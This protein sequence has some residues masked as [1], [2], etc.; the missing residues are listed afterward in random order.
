M[1]M[2]CSSGVEV[3][4][5][6]QHVHFLFLDFMST[7]SPVVFI[8]IYLWVLVRF[9]LIS[10]KYAKI[11]I[12]NFVVQ[13]STCHKCLFQKLVQKFAAFACGMQFGNNWYLAIIGPRSV[14]MSYITNVVICLFFVFGRGGGTFY[15]AEIILKYLLNRLHF[16]SSS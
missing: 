13:P 15:N 14:Q 7:W 4:F 9:Y 5:H 12:Y 16:S 6:F 8:Y 2:E 3:R 11:Q 10:F 1:I